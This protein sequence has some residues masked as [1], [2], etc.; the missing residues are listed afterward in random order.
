MYIILF[1]LLAIFVLIP[2]AINKWLDR[3]EIEHLDDHL[4]EVSKT[5]KELMSQ[6]DR[7]ERQ[8]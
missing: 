2:E 7:D 1:A 6:S 4:K 5:M 3:K 8:K